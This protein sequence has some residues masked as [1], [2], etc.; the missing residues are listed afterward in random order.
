MKYLI[1]YSK[2]ID[3]RRGEGRDRN[4]LL[5]SYLS[6]PIFLRIFLLHFSFE[7]FLV[8]S[9][10]SYFWMGLYSNLFFY[11]KFGRIGIDFH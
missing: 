3:G 9:N 4:C 5:S 2:R 1:K 8:L 7:N 6:P 11:L 10:I